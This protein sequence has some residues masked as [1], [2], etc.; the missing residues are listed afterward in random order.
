MSLFYSNTLG[1]RLGVF[2]I[3]YESVDT[4]WLG[5]IVYVWRILPATFGAFPRQ[6][7]ADFL[8]VLFSFAWFDFFSDIKCVQCQASTN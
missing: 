3:L 1:A 7:L 2:T 5:W 8:D 4:V 6:H